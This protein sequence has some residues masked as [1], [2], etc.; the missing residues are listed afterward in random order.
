MVLKRFYFFLT[1]FFLFLT[2][3]GDLFKSPEEKTVITVGKREITVGELKKDIKRFTSEMGIT[4]QGM[5]QVMEPLINRIIDH[6]L[7][8]EYGREKG[9]FIS[10][11]DLE[12]T[13]RNMEKDY[14]EQDLRK[15]LLHGYIDYDEW[16]VGLKEHLLVKKIMAKASE[17]IPPVSHQEIKMYFNSHPDEFKRPIMVKFRQIVLADKAEAEKIWRRLKQGEDMDQLARE[18]SIAPEADNGGEVGWVAEEHLEL[19]MSKVIFSLPIGKISPVI[20]TVHGYHIFKV[21]SKRPAGLQSL[22]ESITEI[23]SKLYYQKEA[24]FY[25]KWLQQLKDTFPVKINEDLLNNLELG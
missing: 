12:T 24:E 6:Y 22:P 3:C 1:V 14:S 23:E 17:S 9:I 25:K 18:Y 15:I 19:S 10:D 2:G 7:I 5:E 4:D 20:K 8:L 13:L 16:K 11:E 21:L